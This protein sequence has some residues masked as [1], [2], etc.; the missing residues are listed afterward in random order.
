MPHTTP[1]VVIDT[2]G[3]RDE[4]NDRITAGEMDES[5]AHALRGADDAALH[6]AIDASLTDEFWHALDALY[7]RA[8]DQL[9]A[10]GAA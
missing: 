7:S 4:I 6:A 10:Q 1:A 8:I 2:A 3:L 5:T 9:A